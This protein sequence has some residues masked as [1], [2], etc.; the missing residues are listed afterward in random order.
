MEIGVTG[1]LGRLGRYVVTAL[2]RHSVRVLDVGAPTDCRV[3]D[4][5]RRVFVASCI[6]PAV[7]CSASITATRTWRR[8]ICR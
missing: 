2:G 6:A 5:F 7:R 3:A 1:G 8:A 4:L